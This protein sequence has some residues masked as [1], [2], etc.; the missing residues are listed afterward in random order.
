MQ[1]IH[2]QTKFINYTT[3]RTQ[4]MLK[5]QS[6]ADPQ[7]NVDQMRRA[8]QGLSNLFRIEL[9]PMLDSLMLGADSWERWET[10]EGAYE[11]SIHRIREHIIAASSQQFCSTNGFFLGVEASTQP[12][13][14][15]TL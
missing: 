7:L 2:T 9:T 6:G 1:L 10:F 14:C 8:R 4:K 11:E 13:S 12:F 5:L 15:L 3:A